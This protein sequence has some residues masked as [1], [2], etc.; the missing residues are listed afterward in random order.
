MQRHLLTQKSPSNLLHP[1]SVASCVKSTCINGGACARIVLNS[2]LEDEA[3]QSF[4][5]GCLNSQWNSINNKYGVIQKWFEKAM[6]F[7]TASSQGSKTVYNVRYTIGD[8]EVCRAA[9]A[10]RAC[11]RQH[12]PYFHGRPDESPTENA[13]QQGLP[14]STA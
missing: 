3:V 14:Y 2:S 1:R 4:G 8:K 12:C 5:E 7:R 10:G 13:A 9:E 11:T 6:A